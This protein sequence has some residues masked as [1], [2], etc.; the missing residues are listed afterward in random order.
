MQV[1]IAQLLKEPVG[2]CR[3][4]T[5]DEIVGHENGEVF[6]VTG[7]ITLTHTDKGILASGNINCRVKG[8]CYRCLEPLEKTIG[9]NFEEEYLPTIDINTGLPVFNQGD[10][11]LIDNHHNLDL[12]EAIYQYACMSLPMKFLCQENCAGICPYCGQNLNRGKC[13]CKLEM[14]DERWSKL[15]TLKKEGKINGSIT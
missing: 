10:T 2:S 11:F 15:L 8:I 13:K 5:V 6:N 9:Y 14:H 1:N 4:M 7:S 12:S 3:S